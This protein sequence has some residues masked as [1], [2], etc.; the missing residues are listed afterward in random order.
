MSRVVDEVIEE[1][2]RELADEG[3]QRTL[4]RSTGRPEVSSF[5]ECTSR[6]WD[7]SGLATALE[8]PGL[9]FDKQID[10]GLRHLHTTL[11]RVDSMQAVDLLLVDTHLISARGMARALLED[12]RRFGHDAAT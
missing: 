2:L 8:Q 6:L 3:R 12:V 5:V 11:G 4:W 1:A 7:D 10:D 9:V